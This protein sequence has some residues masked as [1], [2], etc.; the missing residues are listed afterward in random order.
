MPLL[1]PQRQQLG[2]GGEDLGHGFLELPPGL[3]PALN[4]LDPFGGDTFHPLLACHHEGERPHG[5][6]LL[7]EG[8]VASGLAT[9]TMSQ[10]QR[11]GEKVGGNGEATKKIEFALAESGGLRA[12]GGD[13]HM[14]VLI[15]T[16]T[17]KSSPCVGMRK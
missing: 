11:T 6:S 17:P 5:V 10:R 7:V 14:S 4:F 12:F 3:D 9:T 8:A 15:H 13:L 2:V 1:P 16:E